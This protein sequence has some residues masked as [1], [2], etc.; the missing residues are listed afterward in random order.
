MRKL[1][2]TGVLILCMLAGVAGQ[3]HQGQNETRTA[4]YMGKGFNCTPGQEYSTCFVLNGTEHAAG[5]QL[6][7]SSG[8]PVA[9]RWAVTGE[10]RAVEAHEWS[11][12]F[13]GSTTVS[14]PPYKTHLMIKIDDFTSAPIEYPCSTPSLATMGAITADFS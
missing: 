3:A 11:F 5:L 10:L 14:I 1:F 13:C 2:T 9:G 8:L 7:D 4:G 12:M 6:T